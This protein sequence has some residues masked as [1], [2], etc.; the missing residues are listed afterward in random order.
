MSNF[1]LW[2]IAYTEIFFEKKLWPDFKIEDLNRIVKTPLSPLEIQKLGIQHFQEKPRIVLYDDIIRKTASIDD[3]FEGY[4]GVIIYYPNKSTG[5]NS[6]YGHYTALTKDD[7]TRTI[8][9][10]DSYGEKPDQ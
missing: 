9:F 4:N 8:Y 7:K 2:Q 6:T 10:F 5:L 1:L 3:I